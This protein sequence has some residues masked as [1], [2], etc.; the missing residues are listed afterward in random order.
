M[1]LKIISTLELTYT[2]YSNCNRYKQTNTYYLCLL[3]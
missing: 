1:K 3:I 2:M